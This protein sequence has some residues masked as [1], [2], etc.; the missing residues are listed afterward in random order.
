M[1]AEDQNAD[2]CFR[3]DSGGGQDVDGW[4]VLNFSKPTIIT[5]SQDGALSTYNSR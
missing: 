3:S 5:S 1:A 2:V 4:L